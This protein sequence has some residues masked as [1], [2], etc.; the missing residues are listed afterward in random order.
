L[1]EVNEL[2]IRRTELL[3]VHDFVAPNLLWMFHAHTRRLM[4]FS[5]QLRILE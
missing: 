3:R 5:V 1:K 4:A 2:A